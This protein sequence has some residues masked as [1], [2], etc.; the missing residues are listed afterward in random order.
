MWVQRRFFPL[1]HN[2]PLYSVNRNHAETVRQHRRETGKKRALKNFMTYALQEEEGQQCG[3]NG[4]F[5][6]SGIIFRLTVLT[7]TTP[8]LCGS[9]AVKGARKGR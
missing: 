1:R 9:I 3:C 6:H 4:G 2:F 8:E 5:V 7:E